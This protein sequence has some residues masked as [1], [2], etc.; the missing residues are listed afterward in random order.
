MLGAY[1]AFRAFSR[2][3]ADCASEQKLETA[4]ADALVERPGLHSYTLVEE[5]LQSMDA[6]GTKQ[7]PAGAA[8]SAPAPV[9]E[10]GGGASVTSKDY[11]GGDAGMNGVS[12]A[13]PQDEAPAQEEAAAQY[14]RLLQSL[15]L[16][17][18]DGRGLYPDWCGG[19]WLD[20]ELLS[21][22]IV[23]GSRTPAL[24]A[25]IKD[26]CGGTGEIL[27]RDVKYSQND[28]DS[29]MESAAKAL[30]GAGICCGISVDV[31]SNCLG[32]DLYSGEAAIPEDLLAALAQLDPDGDAIRVQVFTGGLFDGADG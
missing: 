17:G 30:D 6:A 13:P 18:I 12:A 27:F 22:A 10:S 25:Q 1:P 19:I 24:E 26:W 32:V 28:L 23:D 5:D 31:A 14:G 29:L 4:D 21:V 7:A 3:Q 9:P 20:G 2:R 16:W 11:V 8:D 15:G